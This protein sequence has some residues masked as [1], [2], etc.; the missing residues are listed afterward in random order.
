MHKILA[1]MFKMYLFLKFSSIV[2]GSSIVED[3]SLVVQPP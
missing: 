1:M 3:S 2:D